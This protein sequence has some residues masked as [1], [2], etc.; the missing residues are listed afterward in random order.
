MCGFVGYFSN[1]KILLEEAASIIK[2]RGPDSTNIIYKKNWGVAFNRLSIIDLTESGM[3]PF[4]HE[5]VY[6]FVNGEIY[7]YLELQKEH[8][9]EFKPKSTNDVEIIPFLYKKYGINFINKINGMFSMVI[10]DEKNKIKFLIR[11]RYGKKPLFFYERNESTYF[12]SEVKSLKKL[13]DLEI[14][15]ENVAINL[16]CTM[17][18]QPMSLYKNVFSVPPGSYIEVNDL[19]ICKEKYWYKPGIKSEKINPIKLHENLENKF[20]NSIS[21][22]LRSDVPIGIFLSGGLDSN[23]IAYYIQKNTKHKIKAFTANIENKYQLSKNETDITIPNKICDK[24]GWEKIETKI[25]F[26]YLN[27]NLIQIINHHDEIITNS[28]VILFYALSETAKNNNI[29]VIMTGVGGDELF[30]GYP[31]QNKMRFL[32]R[33]LN[34]FLIKFNPFNF[35]NNFNLFFLGNKENFL[36]HKLSKFFQLLNPLYSHYQALGLDL[37]NYMFDKKKV[38]NKK[39]NYFANKYFKQT[40]KIVSEDLYNQMNY[41]NVFSVISTQNY[42]T[43]MGC[44]KHSIENRAPLLDYEMMELLMKVP[45][46]YKIKK[47]LKSVFKTF[48]KDKLPDFVISSIKSGPSLPI[49]KWFEDNLQKKDI[50]RFILKNI[51]IISEFA[52]RDLSKKIKKDK[53]WIYENKNLKLFAI[54]SMIIWVKINHQKSIQNINISLKQ[55]IEES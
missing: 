27:K 23:S 30:G 51:N 18:P 11:D 46:K 2:H 19:N 8:S 34:K 48:M 38:T 13:F 28:G 39:L 10:I 32:P 26:E 21:L 35:T 14:D 17:L 40:K 7:N 25:D 15:K 53:S 3:Q 31:W 49:E 9:L 4:I 24:F 20:N 6:A 29:K 5:D 54:I 22:R 50:E 36:Q 52:S 47:G 1:K 45:D 44:M 41:F 33:I 42:M 37:Q 43:D 16:F 12:A 55:L